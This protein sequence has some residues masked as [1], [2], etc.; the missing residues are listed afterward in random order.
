MN[1][2]PL[3]SLVTAIFTLYMLLSGTLAHAEG[4]GAAPWIGETFDGRQCTGPG[5]ENYGPFDFRIDKNKLPIVENYHF[6]QDVEQLIRGVSVTHPIGDIR[7]TLTKIPNHHRA[8]YSAVRFSISDPSAR[9]KREN[10]AE[11]FLQRAIR[12]APDDAVPHMLFGLYLHRLGHPRDSLQHYLRAEALT[13]NDVNLLYNM[14]LVY[15]DLGQY[16]EA[17]RYAQQAYAAG[18][19]FP[20]LKRKL[21]QAGHWD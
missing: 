1:T 19:T 4:R 18:V 10:P 6:T 7:Y 20:G 2:H 15:F 11:C 8:L 5:T 12:Y 16:S 17:S 13:P 9:L 21:Q 3:Q 14:G